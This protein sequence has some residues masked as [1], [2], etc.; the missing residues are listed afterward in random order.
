MKRSSW[1]T[2]NP[3]MASTASPSPPIANSP[4][5]ERMT[6][7]R[8]AAKRSNVDVADCKGV[9]AGPSGAGGPCHP[10]ATVAGSSPR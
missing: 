4:R 5:V 7:G 3:L 6:L 1:S 8:R 9:G 2:I 10:A